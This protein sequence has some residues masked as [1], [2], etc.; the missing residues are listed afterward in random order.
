MPKK[1]NFLTTDFIIGRRILVESPTS[2]ISPFRKKVKS[3][4]WNKSNWQL[5][6][7]P[8]SSTIMRDFMIG[9]LRWRKADIYWRFHLPQESDLMMVELH[10]RGSMP[11]AVR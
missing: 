3:R 4:V 1:S 8:R 5:K 6:T 2:T 11:P 9:I 10:I 7:E